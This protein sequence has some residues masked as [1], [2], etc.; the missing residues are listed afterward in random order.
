MADEE[1]GVL[2]ELDGLMVGFGD[3]EGDGGEAGAGEV[4]DAVL[5][6]REAEALS[7]IGGG[8]A[9][10]GDVGYVARLRGSIGAFR[11]AR[12]CVCRGGPRRL[13]RR[14]RRSRGSGRCCG[15][16]AA[17]RGGNSTGR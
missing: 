7:A 12:R 16:S 11:S 10:L 17:S 5:E 14:R 13:R 3:G 15:G 9:E 1:A 6:E 4:V 8:D 2:V